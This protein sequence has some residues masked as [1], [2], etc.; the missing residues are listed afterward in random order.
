MGSFVHLHTHS[1]FSLLDGAARVKDQVKRAVDQGMPAL[2]VTDHGVLYGAMD[3]YKEAKKQNLKPILGFEAY[4]ARRSRL[5][6]TARLDDS[7]NHLVLLARNDK[8]Y[9]NLLQLS[10]RGFLEGFYYKPRIDRELL[11]K[12]H[13]G[14]IVLSAC[15]AGEIPELIMSGK[16]SEAEALASYYA[17]LL[18]KDN[19][20]L[21]IQDH[22]LP[23]QQLINRE[24]LNIARKLRLPLVATNDIHY[25]EKN[26][27]FIQDVLLCIQ[28]GKNINDEDRMR[29][30]GAE[31]YF[32]SA[33]EME[34][35]FREVPEALTNTLKIAEMCN[36]EFNF[37][38]F[39]L[40]A[41]D[42]PTDDTPENFLRTL[43]YQNLPL[44]YPNYDETVVER[45]D[46]ELSVINSMGFPGYF[47]IVSDL[48]SWAK[49][50]G[51]AVGPGRGSAAG[52]LVSYLL[53]ITTIDPLAYGLIFERFLNPERVSMPDIDIDF[54]FERRDEVIDYI[55]SRYGNDRVAQIITF[56]TMAARAAIRDVGRV[57]EYSYAE[58]DRI[59]KMIPTEWGSTLDRSLQISPD[60]T[61]I[62]EQ[63]YQVR[64]LVDTARAL[65]GIP[66]HHSVHAAGVVIGNDELMNLLPLQKT[67]D[68][69]VVTQ[70]TK[71]TVEEIG[72]LKMDILGLRT[73]TVLQRTVEILEKTRGIKVVLE[74][75]SLDDPIVYEL[76][77]NG[78]S[79]GVFQLES[80][81]LRRLLIEMKPNRFEDLIAVIALYRPGPLGSGMVEDFIKCKNGRQE[82]AYVDQMVQPVVEETYGVILYQEQVMQVASE[83]AAF[84][85][86][87]A[88]GL[89][90]AMG[91]KKPEEIE[92][93]RDKFVKGAIVSGLPQDKAS[94]I[95]DLMEHFAGYGFN[96]S[97]S[98]AYAMISYQTAYLKAHYPVEYMTAFLS[99][100]IDNQDRVVFYIRECQR[101]GIKILPPD[102]NESFENFT[103]AGDRIRFG[104][105]A[106]KNVGEAAYRS[107]ISA[108]KEAPFDS[109]FDFCRRVDLHQVNKRV[110]ENLAMAGCFDS[111]GICRREALQV[112]DQMLEIAAGM[113]AAE[114]SNQLSLFGEEEQRPEEPKPS[115]KGEFPVAELLAREKEILGFYVSGNPLE[116]YRQLIPFYSSHQIEDMISLRDGTY[117][118]L[119]GMVSDVSRKISRKGEPWASFA[120]EDL[121]G[122]VE[123]VVFSVAYRQ[124]GP[125]LTADSV[126]ALEGKLVKQDELPK[127]ITRA[128]K[129]LTTTE[130]DVHVRLNGK[131]DN[132]LRDQLLEILAHH[133][134]EAPVY[135]HLGEGRTIELD[136]RYWVTVSSQL[137]NQLEEAFGKSRVIVNEGS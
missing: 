62:Y 75:L 37:D 131:K 77:S 57:L 5:D 29:F 107:V 17:E 36:V 110:L 122:K 106:I 70:F 116:E 35:L 42:I 115:L 126:I 22:G 30:S 120:L 119:V 101:M 54:C 65:E 24:M 44:K 74:E 95:F 83:L 43:V 79:I 94:Y 118:R 55:V 100:V 89:R 28:T 59:A 12:Y 61:N 135:L 82:I 73:L 2:A 84:S 53:S 38:H 50:R 104:L 93:Q 72:L 117:V 64:R 39:Y 136:H 15:M 14:L 130:P 69:H 92:K 10:S 63:D 66:R 32:K 76:L 13:E 1:E 16:I 18:G 127:V 71:E 40:P 51:I 88:D 128:V 91:K 8:G 60:L 124:Y 41:F 112:M 4:M 103:V 25:L 85:M 125:N 68:G 80:D 48:V 23:E 67:T 81:G 114:E 3:F 134:G 49:N 99:S 111:L 19:F 34:M 133:P 52:S 78:D 21:E 20:Y 33:A 46:Y 86:G 108:R 47:L 137:R 90:R 98:A 31:F 97:H 105:G 27:A 129:V 123:A 7:Q 26:D 9:R 109:L 56:G 6:R 58:T 45:L 102:I 113:R 121:T 11:E 87:E 96:K 132:G